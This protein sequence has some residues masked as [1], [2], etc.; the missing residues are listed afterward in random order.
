M[1]F[2]QIFDGTGFQKPFDAVKFFRR[3]MPLYA[4]G[5]SKT[6]L[7]EYCGHDSAKCNEL[8]TLIDRYSSLNRSAKNELMHKLNELYD[9]VG[10]RSIHPPAPVA[11]DDSDVEFVGHARTFN[12]IYGGDVE[13]ECQRYNGP[14]HRAKMRLPFEAMPPHIRVMHE[15]LRKRGPEEW[16]FDP[17]DRRGETFQGSSDWVQHQR[18]NFTP[19]KEMYPAGGHNYSLRSLGRTPS[20]AAPSPS[21]FR[22]AP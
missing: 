9:E 15:P 16:P 3:R 5:G 6:R 8:Q 13:E 2:S 7:E 4:D 11:D 18:L 22:S 1:P 17:D 20:P 19:Y 14:D 21:L 10:R 12:T